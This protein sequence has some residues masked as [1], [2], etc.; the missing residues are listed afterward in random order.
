[1][2]LRTAT[3]MAVLIVSLGTACAQ[4]PAKVTDLVSE[5]QQLA[6]AGKSELAIDRLEE[7]AAAGFTGLGQLYNDPTFEYLHDEPRYQAVVA[8]VRARVFPCENKPEHRQFDFWAGTW[9]VF[10]KNGTKAGDNVITI[11]ERGCVLEEVWT[12]VSGGTGRSLNFYDAGS[13][14]W[15]QQWVSSAG[16]LINIAGGLDEEGSMV[17]TGTS[18]YTT[19]G[20]TNPFRGKWT[21]LDDGRV[22]QYFEESYDGGE[23]WTPWFEGFYVRSGG[24]HD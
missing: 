12:S 10:M 6:A 20:K 16:L 21:L 13:G 14:K 5:A 19:S 7:A 24:A 9:E 11:K 4:A 17:L 23:T 2:A 1:M 18:F 3:V 8:T 22:R 15:V